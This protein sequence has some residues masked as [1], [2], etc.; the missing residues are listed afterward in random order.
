MAPY[1][2]SC[3]DSSF[4]LHVVVRMEPLN[5]VNEITLIPCLQLQQLPTVMRIHAHSSLLRDQVL[6]DQ[7]LPLA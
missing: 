4:I 3:P 6:L 7:L 1:C 5:N 2:H